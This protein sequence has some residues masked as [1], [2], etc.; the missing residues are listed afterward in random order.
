M[1]ILQLYSQDPDAARVP[2]HPALQI[3]DRPLLDCRAAG[4]QNFVERRAGSD[5]LNHRLGGGAYRDIAIKLAEQHNR[6]TAT[7]GPIRGYPN[8]EPW[9]SLTSFLAFYAQGLYPT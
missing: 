9:T 1:H 5:R 2:V 7:G 3:P 8:P 4:S 6:N